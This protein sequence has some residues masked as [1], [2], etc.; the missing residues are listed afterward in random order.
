MQTYV[1]PRF[2]PHNAHLRFPREFAERDPDLSALSSV[3][4]I[5][6]PGMVDALPVSAPGIYS[7]TGGR[8]TG[9]TTLLKQWMNHLLERGTDPQDILYVTG[10]LIDDHHSLVTTLRDY[11]DRSPQGSCSYLLVDEV[12]YIRE[13]DRGVKYLADAGLLRRV[14]L[15]VTGSDQVLIRDARMRL[16]G[17]RGPADVQD[18]HLYPLSFH[19]FVRLKGVF[20]GATIDAIAAE[21]ACPSQETAAVL[22]RAFET[23]LITGGYLR[24]INDLEAHGSISPAVYALYCDWI[25]GDVLKRGKNERYLR[26]VLGAV[27]KRIGSQ[28]TWNALASDLSID[29]PA[30]VADYVGLL[31]R[32]DVLTILPAL[33]E[34][35]LSGAPKKAR[36]VVISDPFIF[37]A[38]RSWLDPTVDP[39][40]E[41]TLPLVS[42]PEWAGRLAELCA[43]V[44]HGRLHPTYYIKAEGEVDIAYVAEGRFWPLEVKW[45]GQIRSGDIKQARKYPNAVVLSRN[46]A[47]SLHGIRNELLPLHLLRLG[48]SPY[49]APRT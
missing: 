16:P 2:L 48:P 12:T 9:K 13:W 21:G 30:T 4:L 25:R 47:P 17:R 1:D 28:I 46:T 8:Q 11:L 37:H 44:H 36:K 32:M 38:V 23:Y 22:C 31:E 7:V 10:E 5:H 14:V 34:D 39:F 15:V 49:V 33:M 20:P 27:A 42:D 18:F 45:S 35:R 43:D 26:E 3:P 40:A 29:H 19:D 41:R 6:R 24:A